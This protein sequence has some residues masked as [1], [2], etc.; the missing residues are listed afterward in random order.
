V[1]DYK[2][3]VD[4]SAATGSPALGGS[5]FKP[6]VVNYLD[7]SAVVTKRKVYGDYGLATVW[8]SR[9]GLYMAPAITYGLSSD[10]DD[11]LVR[12]VRIIDD[13]NSYVVTVE[14]LFADGGWDTDI[15]QGTGVADD[16]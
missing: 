14:F 3:L 8:S 13:S 6:G 11:W 5:L 9:V 7:A 2:Y 1:G 15:Y 4:V 10:A 16:A 12:D